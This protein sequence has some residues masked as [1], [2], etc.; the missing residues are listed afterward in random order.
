MSWQAS[1]VQLSYDFTRALPTD[2]PKYIA[3]QGFLNEFGSDGNTVVIGFNTANFY[4]LHFFNA[5]GD[6][7]QRLKKFLG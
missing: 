4:D 3:Y 6:L 5:V 2:N 1:K 7:H